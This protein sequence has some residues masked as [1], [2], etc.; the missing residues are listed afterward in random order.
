MHDTACRCV[1]EHL[2]L[3]TQVS[4][5]TSSEEVAKAAEMVSGILGEVNVLLNQREINVTNKELSIRY[6]K[7][8]EHLTE[9]TR[10]EKKELR[11]EIRDSLRETSP[12]GD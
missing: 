7:V 11:Y 12:A 3:S 4:L 2:S 10:A 1:K 8:Q 5:V 9:L 6:M